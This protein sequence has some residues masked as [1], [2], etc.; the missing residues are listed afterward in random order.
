MAT[1]LFLPLL[2][3]LIFLSLVSSASSS[4]FTSIDCGAS[5]SYKD[6][7]GIEWETDK[8]YIVNGDS[9]VVES[10]DS[11][12][13]PLK[14]LRAFSSRKKNCYPIPV[15]GGGRVLV[16]ATFYY[17]NYDKK[18]SP[19]TFALQFDANS[20]TTVVTSLDRL[21]QHEAI[22]DVFAEGTAVCVAQTEPGQ[23][24]FVT[25][26]ELRTLEAGMY[27]SVDSSYAL[28]PS[29][30]Y[31]RIWAPYAASGG[32]VPAKSDTSVMDPTTVKDN[33]PADVLFNAVSAENGSTDIVL[34][35]SMLPADNPVF[36]Y[37]NL[38]FAGM[39]Q[40][41]SNENNSFQIYVDNEIMGTTINPPY[42][43]A[44]ECWIL[45]TDASAST[46]ITLRA[47]P[48]ATL[49]PLISAMEVFVARDGLSNGTDA[50]DVEG[51]I[52]LQQKFEVLQEWNGDP[53]LPAKYNVEWVGCS[54]SHVTPRVTA[55]YLS[56][57][58]LSGDLPDFSTLT[59]LETIDLSNNSI[60]GNIPEF[61]GKLPNL[62]E[63]N[64]G[65]NKLTGAIPSSLL[66]NKNIKLITCGNPDLSSSNGQKTCNNTPSSASHPNSSKIIKSSVL[67]VISFFLIV[68]VIMS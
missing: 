21:V 47:T 11:V 65:D 58:G 63:L 61:L 15:P 1:T 6:K 3:Q 29:D 64:L 27:D 60:T 42:Q 24:P 51:L 68:I 22:Y 36:A 38:Y 66:K 45:V 12:P 20:W 25:A 57:Y 46:N 2:L 33:P 55:L 16:R 7:S 41:G 19:P 5:G 40:L 50:S 32:L 18:R 34:H 48:E 23:M 17:G 26:I 28:Y 59:A 10:P 9:H 53:C 49:P 56:G 67:T 39:S 31:D 44:A 43:S 54:S 14:T 30:A 52:A 8:D 62:K 13:E 37:V 35:L 4:N